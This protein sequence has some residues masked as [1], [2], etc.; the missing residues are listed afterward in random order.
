MAVLFDGATHYQ[1]GELLHGVDSPVGTLFARVRVAGTAGT[2][3]VVLSGGTNLG[4]LQL[5]LA[6]SNKWVLQGRDSG[7]AFILVLGSNTAY[8]PASTC[9]SLLAS[10]RLTVPTAGHFYVNDANDLAAAPTLTAGSLDLTTSDWFVGCA[11][12]ASLPINFWGGTIES[13]FFATQ[14]LDLSVVANRRLFQQGAGYA[15][16]AGY[17]VGLGPEGRNPFGERPILYLNSPGPGVFGTNQGFGGDF[18]TVGSPTFASGCQP[19][20]ANDTIAKRREDDFWRRCDRCGFGFPEHELVLERATGFVV[21]K[22]EARPGCWSTDRDEI[23]RW[24]RRVHRPVDI[25][26]RFF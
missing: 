26:R 17:P 11:S 20:A 13:L 3:R 7:G 9:L 8:Q 22:P 2:D 23:L 10:W 24:K 6:A 21:C 1:R 5:R 4:N 25:R 19:P 16:T 14:Y 12:G 15:Q 18:L